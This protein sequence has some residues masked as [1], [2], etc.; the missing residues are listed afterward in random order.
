[1]GVRDIYGGERLRYL[2]ALCRRDH[3]CTSPGKIP[4]RRG[5]QDEPQQVTDVEAHANLLD[6]HLRDGGN[7]GLAVPPGELVLDIDK[8][9]DGEDCTAE[10]RD[11]WAAPLALEKFAGYPIA[12]T[13]GRITMPD[14]RQIPHGIHVW[15]DPLGYQPG[16]THYDG[17]PFTARIAGQQ[18]VAEPSIHPSGAGYQWHLGESPPNATGSLE[19][20]PDPTLW[21]VRRLQGELM[22]RGDR[23]DGEWR[24]MAACII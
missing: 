12:I 21:Q 13:G 3:D 8:T 7:V 20:V 18:V 22:P 2:I 10:N 9:L 1:M 17:I 19:P 5:W 16:T 4:H 14:G 24:K 15:V 11:R 23:S 6:D